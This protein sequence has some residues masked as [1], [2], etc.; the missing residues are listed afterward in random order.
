MN[1]AGKAVAWTCIFSTLLVGCTSSAMIDP[2]GSEKERVY[3]DSIK[4]VITRDG[5]KYEFDPPATV[6]SNAIVGTVKIPVE[7]GSMTKQISIPLSE[8]V[9]VQVSE[10]S[11]GKTLLL[12]VGLAA[13]VALI[14]VASL[15]A[16]MND[17]VESVK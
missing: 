9:R 11:A 17:I 4:M 14:A 1:T 8:V 10:F 7:A 5:T 2:A 13:I 6:V 16:S 12:G 15:T 3:T